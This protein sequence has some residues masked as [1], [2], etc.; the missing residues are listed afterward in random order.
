[1]SKLEDGLTENKI[2]QLDT[3]DA[4]DNEISTNSRIIVWA[5]LLLP[6]VLWAILA[7]RFFC[8]RH[9]PSDKQSGAETDGDRERRF[10][11]KKAAQEED[12]VDAGEKEIEMLEEKNSWAFTGVQVL[13]FQI[14]SN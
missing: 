7:C 9:S 11:Y 8:C 12:V 13:N 1:M 2:E 6:A 3:D 14:F 10:K 5:C 4:S